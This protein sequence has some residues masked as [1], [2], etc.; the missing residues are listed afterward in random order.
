L[1]H[2][3]AGLAAAF[4]PEGRLVATGGFDGDVR[5]WDAATGAPL[6]PALVQSGPI[7]AIAF[8]SRTKL[9]RAAGKDG[10]LALWPV[11]DARE[12]SPTE[13]RLWGAVDHRT[14]NR[15]NGCGAGSKVMLSFG[16]AN[17]ASNETS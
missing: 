2:R 14:G 16:G 1:P 5:L 6:G 15:R 13:I 9:L 8:V 10:N 7:P 4:D 3:V 17:W 11:P 12:G